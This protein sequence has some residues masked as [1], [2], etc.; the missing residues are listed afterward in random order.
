MSEKKLPRYKKQNEN[1]INEVNEVLERTGAFDIP[2]YTQP[3]DYNQYE[4]P[5]IIP[6]SKSSNDLKMHKLEMI[7][8]HKLSNLTTGKRVPLKT[9]A[10]II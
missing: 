5:N 9:P 8:N 2:N 6:N 7:E 3:S 1:P 10:G 4:L